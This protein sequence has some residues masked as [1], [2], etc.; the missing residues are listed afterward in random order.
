MNSQRRNFLKTTCLGG[1]GLSAGA[2]ALKASESLPVNMRK[3]P[4]AETDPEMKS[5]PTGPVRN[6][7]WICTDQQRWDTLGVNG[8]P[9][10]Q[11]PH[12]DQLADEGVLFERA[13]CNNPVCMP[14]RSSFLTGLYPTATGVPFNGYNYP[15]EL[16]PHLLTHRLNTHGYNCG[17]AG[18]LHIR[19]DVRNK[20]YPESGYHHGYD[21]FSWSPC[22]FPVRWAGCQYQHWLKDK[23][24]MPDV[25]NH[26]DSKHVQLNVSPEHH[27]T[28]WCA[29][30]AITFMQAMA[31][32]QPNQPWMFSCNMFDPHNPTDPPAEMLERYYDLL[33]DIPL[34][35][36]EE[37]E[38]ENKPEW[39][40][41]HH[42]NANKRMPPH[43][44][45]F[46]DLSE[47]EH[48]LYRAGYYAMIDL[49]DQQV[50]RILKA[51]EET[52]Q[53]EN[54]LVIF[55][56]DHGESLGDHG[57]YWKQYWC[58]EESMRVP[59]IM[60][61]PGMKPQGRRVSNFAE[62][63]DIVPTIYDAI[64]I[65]KPDWLHGHSWWP[66]LNGGNPVERDFA[67]AELN[68]WN[69]TDVSM[70]RTEDFK[71]VK[72]YASGE[73]ELY[74]Y[75]DPHLE[76]VNHFTEAAYQETRSSLEVKMNQR[77]QAIRGTSLPA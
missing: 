14:S 44:L 70:V 33:D 73:G 16:L 62:L 25:R 20:A 50:G 60:S 1:L 66:Y 63:V 46:D 47:H 10:V 76:R 18:K 75:R 35:N 45:R 57:L 21:E 72:D 34:P 8:N 65:R 30:R 56:S 38:L 39:Q 61:W 13:Y 2:S 52:G 48:K 15:D 37:G 12:L 29:Q 40:R 32:V 49:I 4:A 36:Y 26:P 6:I 11:T 27:Q 58:Y 3:S 19:A 7:L 71:L 74:D 54:T 53:R 22:G 41:E 69:Q 77:R 43:A 5:A 42:A 64:G 31:E 55:T 51:L 24:I 9:F 67:Y 59:L 68:A 23:G 17:L 28:S